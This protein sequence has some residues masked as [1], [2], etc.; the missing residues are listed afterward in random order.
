MPIGRG[1]GTTDTTENSDSMALSTPDQTIGFETVAPTTAGDD[2]QGLTTPTLHLT[3]W[4]F[5]G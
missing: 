2:G 5:D 1:G 3:G 4:V